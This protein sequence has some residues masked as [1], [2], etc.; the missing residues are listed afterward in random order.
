MRSRKQYVVILLLG[1]LLLTTG[2][3]ALAQSS[4]DYDLSWHVIAGGGGVSQSASFRVDGTVGQAVSGPPHSAANG[5]VVQSGYW[6]FAGSRP[7]YLPFFAG[8]G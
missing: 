1:G 2:V 8:E 5:F 6:S 7:L 3:W 4:A